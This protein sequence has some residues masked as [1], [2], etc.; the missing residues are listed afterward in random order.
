ME[1]VLG[2]KRIS[3]RIMCVKMEFGG[4]ADKCHQSVCSPNRLSA[5]SEGSFLDRSRR[6]ASEFAKTGESLSLEQIG[7]GMFAK[8]TQVMKKL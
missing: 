2:V 6:S 8:E 5:R 1:N 7:M 3:D 4:N